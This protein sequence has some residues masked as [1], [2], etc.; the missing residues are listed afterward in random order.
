MVGGAR[1]SYSR[2][3]A[4]HNSRWVGAYSTEG[5][6]DDDDD[7]KKKAAEADGEQPEDGDDVGGRQEEE[8]VEAAT[9]GA[10]GAPDVRGEEEGDDS[11]EVV[12]AARGGGGGGGRSASYKLPP[13]F[14]GDDYGLIDIDGDDVIDWAN[15]DVDMPESFAKGPR[16]KMTAVVPFFPMRDPVWDEEAEDFNDDDEYDPELTYFDDEDEENVADL[17]EE[18][19]REL[20]K[21]RELRRMT[22]RQE[23]LSRAIDEVQEEEG[24]ILNLSDE[25]REQIIRDFDSSSSSSSSSAAASAAAAADDNDI[26]RFTDEEL[27]IMTKEEREAVGA[28][29]NEDGEDL[30]NLSA[31]QPP[32]PTHV[33]DVEREGWLYDMSERGETIDW[34]PS[35][36]NAH[37]SDYAKTMMFVLHTKDP[38]MFDVARLASDFKLRH[39]RVMAILALK[40]IQYEAETKGTQPTFPGLTAAFEEL[41]GSADIGKD[42]RHI[43]IV[44]SLPKFQVIPQG[45]S[46]ERMKQL[47]PKFFSPEEESMREEKLLVKQFKAALEYNLGIVAPGLNRKG[48]FKHPGKRPEGGWGLMVI[49][50]VENNS[51]KVN[52]RAKREGWSNVPEK[53]YVAYP[54]GTKRDINEDEKEMFR[55]RTI[56]PYRRNNF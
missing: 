55:R 56:R 31:I 43:R 27:A 44:P 19:M 41:H 2:F 8:N 36:Q 42:D 28:A 3:I 25:E 9:D 10:D 6:D 24:V 39:Q 17:T 34:N 18:E 13:R 22:L 5:G 47:L 37:I 26:V 16:V 38:E 11:E 4:G 52:K 40:K 1:G 35:A 14:T 20:M 32:G 48:R 46:P 51:K 50:M 33:D 12:A 30:E 15:S 29:V 21:E 53:P 23:A 7:E 54:D 45:T 49:P